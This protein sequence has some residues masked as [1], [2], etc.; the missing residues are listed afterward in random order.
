M[1][2]CRHCCPPPFPRPDEPNYLRLLETRTEYQRDL[3][4]E[5][6]IQPLLR[7]LIAERSG[8]VCVISED[9]LIEVA[10]YA[11]QLQHYRDLPGYPHR[12]AWPPVPQA[13]QN[14]IIA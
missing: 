3:L 10:E 5:A 12:I 11:E 8:G 7:Q 6:A 2:G 9:A 14:T 1:P 13:L 4:L